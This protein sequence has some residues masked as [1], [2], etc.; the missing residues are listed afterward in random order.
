M[1]YVLSSKFKQL[2]STI[3]LKPQKT[4]QNV[5]SSESLAILSNSFDLDHALTRAQEYNI[6]L[7]QIVILTPEG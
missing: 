4:L 3:N 6:P 7:L 5:F 1:T 2:L